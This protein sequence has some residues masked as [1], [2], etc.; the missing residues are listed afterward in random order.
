LYSQFVSHFTRVLAR[1]RMPSIVVAGVS[2]SRSIKEP[3]LSTNG[4]ASSFCARSPWR[5]VAEG[6]AGQRATGNPLD[7]GTFRRAGP[8]G[9][10]GWLS[11]GCGNRCRCNREN[12]NKTVP[13]YIH[14]I[15]ILHLIGG[16]NIRYIG[17]CWKT[18]RGCSV[19]AA[20]F[21]GD[22][23]RGKFHSNH[24]PP[25]TS[26]CKSS[27]CGQDSHRYRQGRRPSLEAG[28]GGRSVARIHLGGRHPEYNK[29]RLVD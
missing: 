8:G 15:Y 6:T 3:C 24:R 23:K 11:F 10:V 17:K 2:H 1:A 16:G 4:C 12:H 14:Y 20:R 28:N 9:L 18:H 7:S 25:H 26:I 19:V 21:L 27:A 13:F 22:F 29:S 5:K